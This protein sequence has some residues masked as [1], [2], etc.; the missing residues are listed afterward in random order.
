MAAVHQF[1]VDPDVQGR[2]I[3]RALLRECEAWARGNGFEELVMDTADQASHLI[4]F[5]NDFG[6]HQVGLVRWPGKVY[7]SVV[8]AKRLQR[9]KP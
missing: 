3:G 1:A 6:Y 9:G 5:Y 4:K 2:G 8:L 7:R